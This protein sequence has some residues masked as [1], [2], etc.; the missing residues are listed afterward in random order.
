ML[1]QRILGKVFVW[2]SRCL[3][4]AS[5]SVSMRGRAL[6][7]WEHLQW[8]LEWE[9]SCFN[10]HLQVVSPENSLMSGLGSETGR[11]HAGKRRVMLHTR[12]L[13]GVVVSRCSSY[14]STDLC[15]LRV[16]LTLLAPH[17]SWHLLCGPQKGWVRPMLCSPSTL[18]QHSAQPALCLQRC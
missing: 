13:E 8:R 9:I 2:K 14:F 3:Q 5:I 17:H 4:V 1:R 12:A 15:C 10:H 7:C 11:Q 18:F 6:V 16:V